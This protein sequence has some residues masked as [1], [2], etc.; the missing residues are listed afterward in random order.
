MRGLDACV[1]T[2]GM[3]SVGKRQSGLTLVELMVSMTLGLLVVMAATGLLVS[4]KSNYIAQD[5]DTHVQDTGRYAL[6]NITRAVRQA[7]YENWD[8]TEAPVV[9]GETVSAN[10]HGFD[11]ARLKANTTGIDSPIAA[12]VNGSDVLAIRFFGAGEG[13]GDGTMLNCA[14]FAIGAVAHHADADE[15]R[16]WSIYYVKVGPGGE[17]ELYC[18]FLGGKKWSAQAI[19]R[20]VESFQVLYGLDSDGDGLPNRMLNATAI[21]ALDD[22]LVLDGADQAAKAFDL[23]RKTHWKKV[24]LVKVALLVRGALATRADQPDIK[25]DLLGS[26]YADAYAASDAGVRIDESKLAAGVRN[27]TR[28]LFSSTIQL[29][30]QSSGSG[31]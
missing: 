5:D 16:G 7:A 18:K 2:F 11:S 13:D 9:A 25:Y 28:R 4:S 31:T 3:P 8:A 22:A 30:N 24:V 27:R 6:E 1:R 21:Q 14:G 10:I 12:D 20:G 29:R 19:A 17:P 15:S 23:N 26:D